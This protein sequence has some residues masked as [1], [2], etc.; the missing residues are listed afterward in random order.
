MSRVDALPQAVGLFP[1]PLGGTGT[2]GG[3]GGGGEEWGRGR[4]PRRLCWRR[5]GCFRS[6]IDLPKTGCQA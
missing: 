5:L 3:G 2:G 4:L 1:L 6:N